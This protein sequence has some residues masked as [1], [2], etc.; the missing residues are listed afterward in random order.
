M[1][2]RSRRL[3]ERVEEPIAESVPEL[4]PALSD[5]VQLRR[6]RWER[7]EGEVVTDLAAR[8]DLATQRGSHTPSISNG[9]TY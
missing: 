2:E 8:D 9:V 4:S 1:S 6:I 5:R 3:V 7:D